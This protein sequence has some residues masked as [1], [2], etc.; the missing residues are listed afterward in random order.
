MTEDA[1]SQWFSIGVLFIGVALFLVGCGS[2]SRSMAVP[3]QMVVITVQPL[4]Q[5]VPIGE[6]AT[7][8]VTATGT[9]PLS[10]QWNENGVE[11]AGA[12]GASYTT[13]AVSLGAGGSTSIGSF[14]VTVSNAVNSVTSNAVT[15][16][17][18]PRSP[19][20]GD[21]RY[22]LYEQVDLQDFSP[23]SGGTGNITVSSAGSLNSRKQ[24]ALGSPLGMGSSSLCGED[25]CTWPYAYNNLPP[26]M[27]GLD[28]Y[29]H[30]GEYSNFTMDLASF[31]APNVVFT[32]LDL[33]PAENAYVVSWV[34]TTQSGGFDY[35]ADPLIPPGANQQAQIQAQANL[36]GAESRVITAVSFDASG[37]A[38]LISY[39][40]QGDTTTVYETQTTITPASGVIS[41]ATTLGGQGYIISAF[42]G[43]DKDGY[44]LIGMRVRGDSLPRPIGLFKTTDAPPYFSPV[45]YLAEPVAE[46]LNEQ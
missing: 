37:N 2:N 26:T 8:A 45:V 28:M 46:I 34:Q 39:G 22:L 1:S 32:S 5:T 35:R 27:T 17:A 6:G 41:T 19:K 29:Y 7:F 30:G 9:A 3:S 43:N 31:A 15:L 21:L 38:I 10:Y 13:P 44:I 24:N 11:I 23:E 20:A 4:S 25:A 14:A 16:T 18:G 40:W 33:E 12:T 42:G 36:D